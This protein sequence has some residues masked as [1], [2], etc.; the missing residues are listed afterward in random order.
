MPHGQPSP[1]SME[2]RSII[3][4]TEDTVDLVV[5]AEMCNL[6][7]EKEEITVNNNIISNNYFFRPIIVSGLYCK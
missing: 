5:I 1:K 6:L 7:K 3:L 4:N 2:Q